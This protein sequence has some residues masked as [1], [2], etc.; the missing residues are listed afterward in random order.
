MA[1][2]RRS[3]CAAS[4]ADAR[5]RAWTVVAVRRGASMRDM[6]FPDPARLARKGKPMLKAITRLLNDEGGGETLEYALVVGL[7]VVGCL[8]FMSALGIKVADK[9][10]Q[11]SDAMDL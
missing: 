11:L 7:L 6:V 3:S 2:M 10:T 5:I 1:A 9:W 4:H 8:G